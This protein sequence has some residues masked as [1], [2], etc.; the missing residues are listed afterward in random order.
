MSI[1]V[2]NSRVL[3]RTS[4]VALLCVWGNA[5]AQVS[6]VEGLKSLEGVTVPKV[7]SGKE[8]KSSA[9]EEETAIETAALRCSAMYVIH[10]TLTVPTPKFGE[11][12][13]QFAGLFAQIHILHKSNRTKAK[14]TPNDVRVQRDEFVA[15]MVKGWPDVKNERVREAAICNVW[16]IN[17]FSKLSE[18]PT[19]KEFQTA[20]L[21][22]APHLPIYLRRI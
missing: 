3:L 1:S 9:Y 2:E 13:T 18:K 8:I 15:E 5:F 6:N 22:I 7:Q 10:S 11:L 16:R 12:M 4:V 21:N 17:F 20:L 19:E 14:I